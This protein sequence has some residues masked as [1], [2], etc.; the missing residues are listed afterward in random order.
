MSS[1]ILAIFY[2][3]L[4]INIYTDASGKGIG[5]IL[6]QIQSDGQEKPVAYF[7]RKLNDCHG[8]MAR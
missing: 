3:N 5:A 6:K 8:E 7:S 1:P 2:P 4:P